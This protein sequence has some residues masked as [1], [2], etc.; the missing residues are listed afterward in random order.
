MEDPCT[1]SSIVLGASTAALGFYA[2]GS[3]WLTTSL[4]TTLFGCCSRRDRHCALGAIAPMFWRLCLSWKVCEWSGNCNL[5]RW[6]RILLFLFSDSFCRRPVIT[7][8]IVELG[9]S[10]EFHGKSHEKDGIV[11][12]VRSIVSAWR[13]RDC[14][15]VMRREIVIFFAQA[16][17]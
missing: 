10:H 7:G 14:S 15:R 8:D 2:P 17:I 12:V 6:G 1:F 5:V 4:Q 3:W 9:C 13:C 16:L 11:C